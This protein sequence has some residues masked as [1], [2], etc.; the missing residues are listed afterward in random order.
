MVIH[1]SASESIA[2][3]EGARDGKSTIKGNGDG[4]A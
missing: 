2:S 4:E 1:I 3:H